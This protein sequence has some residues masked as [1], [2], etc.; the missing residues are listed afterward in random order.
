M[1]PQSTWNGSHTGQRGTQEIPV[2][3]QLLVLYSSSGGVAVPPVSAPSP[4]PRASV[5]TEAGSKSFTVPERTEYV[6]CYGNGTVG[7]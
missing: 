4:A 1:T 3:R 2:R 5:C 6:S 7:G